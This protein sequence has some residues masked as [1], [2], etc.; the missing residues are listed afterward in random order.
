MGNPNQTKDELVITRI[1]NAPREVVFDAWTVPEQVMKWWGPKEF[2]TPYCKMDFRVG[3]RYVFCMRAPDGN[4]FW[5]TGEYKEIV[6]PERI[7]KTDSF[8]DSNGNPVPASHYG[9]DGEWPE[10]LLISLLFEDQQGKTKFT[11]RHTG[12]PG[13]EVSDMTSASWNESL[14]KLEAILK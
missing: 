14:D 4:E 10:V 8:A 9:I 7:V 12:I 2:T 13:A 5:S 6:R 11:L 1:F 3:G